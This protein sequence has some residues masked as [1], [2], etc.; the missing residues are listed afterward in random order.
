MAATLNSNP[1]ARAYINRLLYDLELTSGG[2]GTTVE[3]L[4]YQLADGSGTA[5]TDVE[6]VSYTGEP[7]IIELQKELSALLSPG[8]VNFGAA[9][10]LSL[11]N[12]KTQIRLNYGLAST[13]TET[14][15]T[16]VSLGSASDVS[17]VHYA[18]QRRGANTTIA[19]NHLFKTYTELHLCPGQSF[20]LVSATTATSMTANIISSNGTTSQTVGVT[21]SLSGTDIIGIGPGNVAA[22]LIE[23][24]CSYKVVF[25]STFS[26]TITV[27]RDNVTFGTE[28]HEIAAY[29][30]HGAWPCVLFRQVRREQI[31]EASQYD[32]R[33]PQLYQTIANH[34]GLGRQK[35][36]QFTFEKFTLSTTLYNNADMREVAKAVAKAQTLFIRLTENGSDTQVP[37]TRLS[38]SSI[39]GETEQDIE[40]TIEGIVAI[41]DEII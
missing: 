23:G 7:H 35:V 10:P 3:A 15:A 14:C 40:L 32:K 41:P 12:F 39:V 27:Y 6:S 18:A 38:G 5:I 36:T 1:P 30:Q 16:T 28:G 8:T 9:I 22:H 11:S 17:T 24:W 34:K 20:F 33:V 4:A 25:T 29:D 26:G 31:E 13:N 21:W 2:S 37:F 19:A